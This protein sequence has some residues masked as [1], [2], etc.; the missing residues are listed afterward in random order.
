MKPIPSLIA[1]S[2]YRSRLR[3]RVL[4]Y[5]A[6]KGEGYSAQ[7]CFACRIDHKRLRYVMRGSPPRYRRERALL[8]L[9]LVRMRHEPDGDVYVATALARQVADELDRRRG[10][11]H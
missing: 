1:K 2:L 11:V 4:R 6:R 3:T 9:Q 7:I 8:V 5:L 10:R